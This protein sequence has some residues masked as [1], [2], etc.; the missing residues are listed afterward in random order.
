M[1]MLDVFM[2]F[3]FSVSSNLLGTSKLSFS[4]IVL[5]YSIMYVILCW[6]KNRYFSFSTQ[7]TDDGLCLLLERNSQ[8]QVLQCNNCRLLTDKSIR[9]IAEVGKV[10]HPLLSCL[11]SDFDWQFLQ[12]NERT[13][14]IL[15]R[16][17]WYCASM[18]VN[19]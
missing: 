4:T 9:R 19:V 11:L 7:L 2:C 17:H 10:T 15:Y 14:S 6:A 16:Q 1:C 12:V 3:I 13:P 5:R 8:L 18:V